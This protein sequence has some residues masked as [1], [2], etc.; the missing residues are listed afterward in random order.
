MQKR[1]EELNSKFCS[2]IG[3]QKGGFK[4]WLHSNNK[5]ENSRKPTVDVL[6][7]CLIHKLL[8]FFSFKKATRMSILSK[9]WLQAWSTLPN[10]E[11]R[12][13]YSKDSDIKI[14]DTVMERYRDGKIPIEKFELSEL[15]GDSHEVFRLIDKWL[16]IALHNGVNDLILNYKLYP[17]PILT[18]F[19]AKSL[20]KLVLKSCTLL[21]VSLSSGVVNRSSLRKLSL[22][23]VKL[24]ENM[25]QTLLNSCPLIVTFIFEYCSGLETNELVN[26]QKIKSVSLKVVKIRFCGGI[27]EIDA[28]NLMSFE[29][30]GNQIPQLQIVSESRQ[31]KHSKII[32]HRLDN[33]NADWFCKLKKFLSNSTSW[34][35][36]SLYFFKCTKIKLEYLQQHHRVSTPQV[37]V[38]DVNIL[39][40]NQEC[41]SFVDALVWSCQP[42]RL[43]LQSTREMIIV[44]IDRLMQMKNSMQSTSHGSNPWYS[45]LKEVK[46]YKFDRKEESWHPMKHKSGELAT[47]NLERYYILLDW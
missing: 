42:R 29:F 16:E 31:L 47:V 38:L 10:L 30:I 20:R 5:K 33:I 13:D 35:Q 36:V 34:S 37:D 27:W 2:E 41:P 26:L 4:V 40:Q 12:V 24:D 8:C 28:P 18:I 32:L 14:L 22:S 44:F 1:D 21:P 19:A 17:V 6:P 23:Y 15:F 25:L 3:V 45:Q 9:T 39:W 7:E 46:T 11:F 43:N